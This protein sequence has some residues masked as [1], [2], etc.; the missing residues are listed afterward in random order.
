MAWTSKGL[1]PSE[2]W[3]LT[4]DEFWWWYESQIPEKVN[5]MA[6]LYEDLQNA[7]QAEADKKN[8]K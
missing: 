2:F 1:L 3:K 7:K 6:E 5:V 8:G 4:I